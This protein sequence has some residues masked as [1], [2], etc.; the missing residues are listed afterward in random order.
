MFWAWCLERVIRIDIETCPVCGEAM[1]I[2]ACVEDALVIEQILAQ[3]DAKAAAGQPAGRPPSRG[4][5][6]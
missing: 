6:G 5:L 2:I 3:F 4:L 1:G